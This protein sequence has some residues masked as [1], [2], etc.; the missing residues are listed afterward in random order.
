MSRIR[1]VLFD[2]DGVIADTEQSN[3]AYLQRA[4]SHYGVSLTDAERKSLLG[5]NDPLRLEQFLRR[6]E[7]AVTLDAF[8][9]YRKTLG[10]TYENGKL[11][12]MPG[13]LPVL[14]ELR[15]RGIGTALVSSTSSYLI[16]AALCR[17]GLTSYFDVVI[18]G[19]RVQNRKPDPEPYRNAMQLL[20]ACPQECLVIEDSPVGIR[21]GKAAG[22][23]VVGFRGSEI[24]QDT[25]QADFQLDTFYDFFNIPIFSE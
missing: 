13:I 16:E 8:R 22:A 17:L 5:I 12:L 2:F 24:R 11:E 10:N 3:A 1:F 19:D 7:C 18:C 6:A 4:L 20:N 15:Q 25:S 23:W 9:A 21:A 14:K